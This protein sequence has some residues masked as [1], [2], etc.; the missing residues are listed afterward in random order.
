[1][2]NL[3]KRRFTVG[4]EGDMIPSSGLVLCLVRADHQYMLVEW[5]NEQMNEPNRPVMKEQWCGHGRTGIPC[6]SPSSWWQKAWLSVCISGAWHQAWYIDGAQLIHHIGFC[7]SQLYLK[8]SNSGTGGLTHGELPLPLWA[9]S[10]AKWQREPG[11]DNDRQGCWKNTPSLSQSLK[12]PFR[13]PNIWILCYILKQVSLL[14]PT[15][16]SVFY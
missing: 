9:G 5:K 7:L 13:H 1:M 11:P 4:V 10:S 14:K 8:Q 16:F 15:F 12:D 3:K 6:Y 2:V